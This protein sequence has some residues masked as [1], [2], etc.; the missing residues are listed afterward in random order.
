M[1]YGGGYLYSGLAGIAGERYAADSLRAPETTGLTQTARGGTTRALYGPTPRI[2]KVYGDIP[3]EEIEGHQVD[4]FY[5]VRG[6]GLGQVPTITRYP[7]ISTAP[8]PAIDT[9]PV[10]TRGSPAPLDDGL[11]SGMPTQY[12][13]Y[14]ALA[15]V[16]WRMMKRS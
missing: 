6:G 3:P 1:G 4:P 12:L 16:A 10:D 5:D 14:G 15:F 11:L 7:A 13:V 2:T 8:R 9:T